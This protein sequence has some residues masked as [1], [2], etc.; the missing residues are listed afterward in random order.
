MKI[1]IVDPKELAKI[2]S[3]LIHVRFL[4]DR[5]LIVQYKT[6]W[7]SVG[8]QEVP[9]EIPSE[10]AGDSLEMRFVLLAV[11][12]LTVRLDQMIGLFVDVKPHTLA[13]HSR[14]A[15][16][17]VRETMNVV[18]L[19]NV[20]DNTIDVRMLVPGELVVKMQTVRL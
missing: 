15:D 13:T 17:N 8:V 11:L 20:T 18:Q 5:E 9:Q 14:G 4:V 10:T 3:V 7:L 12:I 6:M 2:T 16:M 19:K 1:P